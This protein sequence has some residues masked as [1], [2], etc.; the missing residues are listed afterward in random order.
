MKSIVLGLALLLIPLAAFAQRAKSPGD[1][2][3]FV[4]IAGS[5]HAEIEEV[6][7]K[8]TVDL[9]HVEIGTGSGFV[10]SPYGYV[11]T[12]DHVVNDS[13][14]IRITRIKGVQEAIITL[15]TSRIDVC[16]QPD[17]VAAHGLASA[18]FPASVT[19]SDPV[20][21]LAVLFIGGSNLPY[22][23]F[24]DSDVVA[25]GLQVEALGYPLG[26][27]VE[28]G[29][30][31]T[32]SDL[33]PNVSATSGTISALRLNDA[34]ERRYLQI[35]NSVNPGNSGGPLLDR[36]GFAV[37]V[38]RMRLER[39][40]DIAFA[41]PINDVKGFLESH[42]LDQVL[43]SR[44]LKLGPVQI[45]EAK[46]L[47]LRLPETL[48]D[49]S[50]FQSHVE[51]AADGLDIVLRIDRV[52][53]PF[54]PGQLEETLLGGQPFEPL[55]MTKRES[56]ASVRP[57]PLAMQ[58]G[59]AGTSSVNNDPDARMDYAVLDL[60]PEKIVARYVGPSE[61][62]AFNESVLRE[63]L[64]SLQAQRFV[65]DNGI[66]VQKLEWSG[67]NGRG[68]VPVPTGWNVEP[69]SPA[70]CSGLPQP[71]R[72][73]SAFPAHDFTLV[74]RAAVWEGGEIV[75]DVASA[76]CSSQRGSVTGASYASRGVWLGTPYVFEGA[77]VRVGSKQVVQLEVM[78][79]E[80]RAELARALLATW[81]KKATE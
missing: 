70:P 34:G 54:R 77:F 33:V 50:P 73:L 28:V 22:V 53:S 15:R 4:R 21:D 35:T 20:L 81:V 26:R 63:S 76:A 31:T 62:V 5:V 68:V 42:G 18:C 1:G 56:H 10:I 78:A 80:Q 7:V 16:F 9:D 17:A 48:V 11:I 25:T 47:A 66:S 38:I 71:A 13:E 60:G 69:G 58:L 45:L 67:Q 23:A 19:A 14:T 61:R 49:T 39:A 6:G 2:A 59:T 37:G 72:F 29:R 75:P 55:F 36:D 12:N 46:G 65:P 41:I 64:S 40:P 27:D 51:T 24:G 30:A 74:L 43:Q 3:V 57:G 52:L 8:R 44:R 32:V 79:T